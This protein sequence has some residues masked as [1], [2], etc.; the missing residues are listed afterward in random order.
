[1]VHK[2]S[3]TLLLSL[4]LSP[5]FYIC[6]SEK[7]L[8]VN[9]CMDERYALPGNL[10]NLENLRFCAQLAHSPLWLGTEHACSAQ[11]SEISHRKI[12]FD[13]KCSVHTA[14]LG[15]RMQWRAKWNRIYEISTSQCTVGVGCHFVSVRLVICFLDMWIQSSCIFYNFSNCHSVDY[16]WYFNPWP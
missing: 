8:I 12:R 14:D 7:N 5:S 1:M 2:N 6:I 16:K 3:F 10:L 13:S 15:I 11:N 4:S 9:F